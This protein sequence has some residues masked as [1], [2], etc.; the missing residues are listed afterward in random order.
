MRQLLRDKLQYWLDLA[1]YRL[2]RQIERDTN[3]QDLRNARYVKQA[4]EMICCIWALIRLP[5]SMKQ[6][7]ERDR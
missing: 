4:D 2:L 6:I 3:R 5:V 7:N 1:S